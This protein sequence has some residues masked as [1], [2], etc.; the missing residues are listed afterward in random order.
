MQFNLIKNRTKTKPEEAYSCAC[1]CVVVCHY[2]ILTRLLLEEE[3]LRPL[4]VTV[5]EA[6]AEG[7]EGDL[8]I[9]A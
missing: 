3:F 1:D 6:E 7:S 2:I 8:S 9:Y 5:Y 4:L